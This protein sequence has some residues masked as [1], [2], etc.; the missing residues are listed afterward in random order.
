[1]L[2]RVSLL[3]QVLEKKLQHFTCLFLSPKLLAFVWVRLGETKLQQAFSMGFWRC[4]SD[5]KDQA[6][7][8]R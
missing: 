3:K 4:F 5:F 7:G 8:I 1:L 2:L 6:K